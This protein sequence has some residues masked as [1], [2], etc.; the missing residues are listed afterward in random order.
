MNEEQSNKDIQEA[1]RDAI[2]GFCLVIVLLF[3]AIIFNSCSTAKVSVVERVVHDTTYIA[4]YHADSIYVKDSIHV[5]E[6]GDTVIFYRFN[7]KYIERCNTDTIVQT[8]IDSIPVPYEM[9]RIVKERPRF[10]IICTI[11]FWLIIAFATIAL[12]IRIYFK[13]HK[14]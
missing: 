5:K 14:I 10:L 8:R 1:I 2:I 11:L 4:K 12:A 6:S 3:T 13:L 7:T 9:T